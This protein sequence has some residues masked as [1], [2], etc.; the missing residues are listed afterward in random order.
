MVHNIIFTG[1]VLM[2]LLLIP[3]AMKG[4]IPPPVWVMVVITV[5]GLA[6]LVMVFGGLLVLIWV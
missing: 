6:G 3:R 1:F 2:T 4:M 5:P